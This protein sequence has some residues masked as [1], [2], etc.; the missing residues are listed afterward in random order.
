MGATSLER[1][2]Y[3]FF[4]YVD[5]VTGQVTR[6]RMRMLPDLF[7]KPHK[8]GKGYWLYTGRQCVVRDLATLDM[9]S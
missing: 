8:S 3:V 9:A 1:T 6:Y 2:F 4:F 7:M 5:E